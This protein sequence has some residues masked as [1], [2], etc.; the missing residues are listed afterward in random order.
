MPSLYQLKPAFQN[1][2]R[3]LVSWLATMGVTA[4]Q[5]TVAAVI[6]SILVGGTIAIWPQSRGLFWLIPFALLIRLA[7]NAIDGMLAREHGMKT[8]L[9]QILNELGDV[10]SD[11]ALYLPFGLISS[12]YLVV[13]VVILSIISEM[14]GVLGATTGGQRRYEGPMGKSDRAFIFA[15]VSLL[16]G[17]R[18]MPGIWLDAI[19]ISMIVLLVWTLINRVRSTLKELEGNGLDTSVN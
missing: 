5:V 7:L 3:P 18:L 16:F 13:P 8:P 17:L 15:V 11:A 9:G 1:R 4:N 6:L 14:A 2:L 19:W 10:L 12:G